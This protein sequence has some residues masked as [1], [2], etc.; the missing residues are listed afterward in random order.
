MQSLSTALVAACWR[1]VAIERMNT[2]LAAQ[3]VHADAVAEQ[4][5]AGAAAGGVDRDHRDAHLREAGEEA[6]EQFVGDRGLAGA[7]GAG[8]ADDRA[9][10]RRRSC[11]CLRRCA[12]SA[13]S[14]APSSM[15]LSMRP[16]AISSSMR[17]R[18][19]RRSRGRRRAAASSARRDDV[20]DHR[21]QAHVH[22][23]VGVVD[24]LDAVGLQLADFLGRDRAAAAAEHADVAGAA[25]AQHVDHVLEVLDVA[26]LVATTA[27]CRR[28]LPAARRAPRPRRERLWPRWTTS[29]PCAWISRRM[30]LM[31]A[32]WPSNRLAAVTKRSGVARSESR[33]TGC[34]AAMRRG[35]SWRALN[36]DAGI[37]DCNAAAEA[38]FS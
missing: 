20:L 22:A 12:S 16:M 8:D 10:C 37:P 18:W 25:L 11:H 38:A 17:R 2:R 19:S 7:A 1:R 13:S 15:A 9:S 36:T 14:S 27:R 34:R 26:A 33:W 5:A 29:A 35:C 32:S 3:R 21:H 28:R 6:V 31:A 4:R 30:M 23:V 24:A